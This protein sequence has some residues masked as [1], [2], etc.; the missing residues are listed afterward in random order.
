MPVDQGDGGDALFGQVERYAGAER[1]GANHHG[2]SFVKHQAES[3]RFIVPLYKRAHCPTEA[4]PQTDELYSL[5]QRV[6]E[7]CQTATGQTEM[8]RF[9]SR[10]QRLS[11]AKPAKPAKKTF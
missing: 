2:G 11:L 7:Q 1:A 10:R 9:R 4:V 8:C 5:L 3:L 6:H